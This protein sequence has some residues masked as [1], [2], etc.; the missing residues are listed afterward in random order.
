MKNLKVFAYTWT[1]ILDKYCC[2]IPLKNL[3]L[4]SP[5][6]ECFGHICFYFSA[7]HLQVRC[8]NTEDI[9]KYCDK[10]TAGEVAEF[11]FDR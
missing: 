8:S 10:Y 11:Y 1:H 9:L 5:P 3:I 4:K 2:Q 7:S 6:V